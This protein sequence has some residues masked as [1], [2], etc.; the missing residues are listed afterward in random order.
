MTDLVEAVARAIY[1]ADLEYGVAPWSLLSDAERNRWRL[2]A[3]AAL[4]V[5]IKGMMERADK[6]KPE[7]AAV[8]KICIQDV[9]GEHGMEGE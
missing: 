8:V 5:V 9:L 3:R 1:E 6:C 7:Y 4:S 2:C